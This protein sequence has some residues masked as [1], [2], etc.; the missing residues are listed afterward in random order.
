[1]NLYTRVVP[2]SCI[3]C[4]E[5]FT[6][7]V[8]VIELLQKF[9][10]EPLPTLCFSCSHK[11][12]LLFRNGRT[13]YRRKCDATGE[14]IIS[15]FAPEKPYTVYR[16]D[17]WW[18]DAWD[19]KSYGRSIDFSRPFFEQFRELQLQ[20]PRIALTNIKA[21]N[22]EY[23]NMSEG[24]R[25]CYLIFGGDFNHEC[26]HGTFG[27]HN[28]SVV[29]ADMSNHNERCYFLSD[30]YHCY[31]TRFAFN[32]QH[33]ASCSFVSDCTG[34]NDCILC[35]NLV[36]KS[37]CIRNQQLSKSD[38]EQEKQRLLTGSMKAQE[39]LWH[40]FLVMRARRTVKAS[41]IVS[42]EGCTG[43]Y[44][45][46]SKGCEHCYDVWD[47]EDSV[48]VIVAFAAKDVLMCNTIGHRSELCYDMIATI[49]SYNC[50]HSFSVFDSSDIEYS[51]FIFQSTHLFGCV[52]M[53]KAEY[54]ILNKQYTQDEY[55]ALRSK[56][57][58]HMKATGEW[59]K[60]FPPAC[61]CF[62]YNESTAPSYF[63]LTKEQAINEG[64]LWLERPE[65]TVGTTR[66]IQ[67]QDLPDHIRDIS[68]DIQHWAI[69]CPVSR[70]LFKIMRAELEFYRSMQLP[71]P[72]LHPDERYR[73]RIALRNSLVTYARSCE[74]CG[75][76]LQTS[77]SPDRPERVLCER[78]YL[79]AVY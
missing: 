35:T 47:S 49:A 15:I 66:K 60:F 36:Q 25:N 9:P 43:D 63:P 18:S 59:G 77:F 29:D 38:F 68:D 5:P 10:D 11:R 70:K 45:Q 13:L 30:S 26:L 32:S 3:V 21:D 17:T 20:V 54:C 50:R 4:G 28:T 61:S 1:M 53:R 72:H 64:F 57:I 69:E 76:G 75:I 16:A 22:S 6:L 65:E 24:N 33:C 40:E 2:P 34:C 46:G 71:I 78:C 73:R 56:I 7:S 41:N 27:M 42:S 44:I 62:A 48:D 55:V 51:D 39:A 12:R 74:K 52:G 67:A 14:S 37:Y 58:A 31:D 23:C 8:K 19:A 79:E